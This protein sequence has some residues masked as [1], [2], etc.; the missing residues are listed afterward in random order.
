MTAHAPTLAPLARPLHVQ[1]GALLPFLSL[2]PV[3]VAALQDVVDG[4]LRDNPM[5]ERAS[6]WSCGTCGRWNTGG[7]CTVCS[8]TTWGAAEAAATLDWR[9]ELL[10]EAR[11]ELPAAL[12]TPLAL[13]V[14]AIDDHGLLTDI[15]AQVSAGVLAEILRALRSVG[16]PGIA[17][18][19]PLECV[20]VQADLLVAQGRAPRSVSTIASDW[21][22]ALA[23]GQLD[24]IVAGT[25]L[26]EAEIRAA[27]SL[28]TSL[29]RPFVA[30]DESGPP[31]PAVDVVFTRPTGCSDVGVHV[32]DAASLGLQLTTDFD[33]LDRTAREWL[34]PHRREAERLMASVNARHYMLARVAAVLA[35]R[36]RD[37][38]LDSDRVHAPLLR[39]EVAEELG[40]HPATVG[41]VAKD[42]CARLPDGR[43]RPL[44][45][46]FGRTTS[47][48]ERVFGALRE[49]G[50]ATDAQVAQRLAAE[51][52]PLARR[53]V[54]KYRAML[55]SA[56]DAKIPSPKSPRINA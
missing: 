56:T 24:E 32:L 48:A 8:S 38:I 15:P 47:T 20:K 36:Q 51:G 14:A 12:H 7:Q 19:S 25:G 28:L 41:R 17:A 23:A 3:G 2:L 16:P 54:A 34:A 55:R 18:S 42:K 35:V 9:E 50:A 1:R 46:F 31:V 45:G 6:G 37:F 10:L 53:T 33:G 40:V 26:T 11:L 29:V 13:V 43:I 21:L 49:L 39:S 52:F 30:I 22:P 5:L 27:L 44:E 4:A